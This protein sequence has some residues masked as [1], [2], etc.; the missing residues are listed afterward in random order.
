M[1]QKTIKKG[2]EAD[3]MIKLRNLV[4]NTLTVYVIGTASDVHTA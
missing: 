3:S 4:I 2:K 1:N